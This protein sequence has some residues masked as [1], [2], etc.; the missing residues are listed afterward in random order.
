MAT[1]KM[2]T[3]RLNNLS[4]VLTG[5]QVDDILQGA[6]QDTFKG[7]AG[8]AAVGAEQ[9]PEQAPG[10]K[11]GAQPGAEAPDQGQAGGGEAPA[12]KGKIP[13]NLQKQIDALNP[14]QKQELVKLL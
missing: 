1:Q 8:Q 11:W 14:Q 6:A 4:G 10:E 2:P 13:V 7:A 5:K 12:G 3:G 9:E